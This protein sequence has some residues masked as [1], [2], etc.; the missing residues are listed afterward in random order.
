[1]YDEQRTYHTIMRSVEDIITKI[2]YQSYSNRQLLVVPAVVFGIAVLVLVAWFIMTGS[3]VK[4]GVEFTGGSELS[5]Q[6]TDS[7]GSPRQLID[8]EFGGQYSSIKRVP[9]DGS[10]ILTF[11][12]KTDASLNELADKAQS[13]GFTIESSS[14]ISPTFGD[15]SQRLAVI[16]IV[17]AFVGMSVIVFAL[18]RVAVPSLA[19]VL[20]ALSDL[21]IPLA[22]MNLVGIKLTLGTIAALLMLIGY[23]IDSDMLLNDYVIRRKG[24]FYDMVYTAMDTGITMTITSIIAMGV[25]AVGGI[26]VGIPL[27]RDIGMIITVGLIADIMNTYMMNVSLLRWFR[28]GG[29]I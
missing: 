10:Y 3:P 9:S 27:L 7:M 23:S 14:S 12:S 13:L 6:P 8:Q 18:F 1:M 22:F 4:L 29:D 11:S 20:S 19:V 25:M 5:I 16:G 24:D 17:G 21:I 28:Y 2:D 15:N 26:I